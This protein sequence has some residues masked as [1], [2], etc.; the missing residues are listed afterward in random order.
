MLPWHTSWYPLLGTGS[1]AVKAAVHAGHLFAGDCREAL[2]LAEEA[3]EG[4]GGGVGHLP[5]ALASAPAA[6]PHVLPGLPFTP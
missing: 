6:L 2:Q 1:E 3:A 4:K 5:R